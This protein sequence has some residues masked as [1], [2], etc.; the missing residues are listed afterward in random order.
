MRDP[1]SN[2]GRREFGRALSQLARISGVQPNYVDATGRLQTIGIE[3]LMDVLHTLGVELER[4]EDAPNVLRQIRQRNARRFLEPVHVIWKGRLAHIPVRLPASS[5]NDLIRCCWQLESGESKHVEIR[6]MENR[7]GRTLQLPAPRDLPIGYHRLTVEN[8]Q[9]W[10][11]AHI[12]C[13]P[14]RC[15]DAGQRSR[16]WGVFAPH[17]ALH[18]GRSW[19]SGDFTDL[20]DFISWIAKQ[21][22]R[23]F[24]TLPLLP[25]FLANP[26]EPSP[27]SPVSRLFWN[28]FLID[29]ASVPEFEANAGARRIAE[30]PSFLGKLAAL[31]ELRQVDYRKQAE[32]KRKILEK[33]ARS[34]FSRSSPRRQELAE[35]LRDNPRLSDYALFRAVH[36]ER[37]VSWQDW[38]ERMRQGKL[39]GRNCRPA[40]HQYHVYVQWLANEQMT[41]L[42]QAAHRSQVDL[43]LD[44]PLGTHRDGYDTWR[45]QDTFAH[46]A[47]GGAPPDPVFTK[48]QDWGFAPIHPA[49]SRESGHAYLRLCL[50]H[51]L[52]QARMLRFDHVMGL[53]RLYWI[54]RGKPADQGAYVAYPADEFYAM[55]S[56]E[57]H[58]HKA[59]IVG[60]NLGTVPLEVNRAIARHRVS[61]MF[62]AQYELR[63]R[64]PPLR[65]M[66]AREVVGVNTH[67]MPPFAAFWRGLDIDDRIELGLIPQQDRARHHG[68]RNRLRQSLVRFLRKRRFLEG[69]TSDP[70]AVYQGLVRHFGRSAARWLVLNLEDFWMETVSQNTPGTTTER[71]NWRHK[72]RYGIE[73][74]KRLWIAETFSKNGP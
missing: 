28:D 51:H 32:L 31:R 73:D 23:F 22:G 33:L 21:G 8:A 19:G 62:V 16:G 48:G 74:L 57:S 6:A 17:Y 54:P 34:F 7:P 27:Y 49:R 61:G 3:A 68:E 14:E 11:E 60:E 5:S 55:L 38:P 53:H 24:G 59:A 69:D 10:A 63:P 4:A 44:V 39:S 25:Q 41:K 52:R 43:Y 50:Q 20:A 1:L 30:S 46:E 36:E 42:S 40:L 71:V 72:A 56:I 67:D 65:R 13:A 26:C 18:S 29:I 2:A 45:Y 58:R 64:V 9:A 70:A 35:F 47:S 66:G 12:F 37:G 15:Y